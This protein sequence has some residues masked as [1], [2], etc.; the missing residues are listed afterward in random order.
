M[1]S[2]V[3]HSFERPKMIHAGRT[4]EHYGQTNVASVP[5]DVKRNEHIGREESKKRLFGASARANVRFC[6]IPFCF[7]VF[8][9]LP[10][11]KTPTT[12]L[13]VNSSTTVNNSG[14]F[15][16]AELCHLSEC[17]KMDVWAAILYLV[18]FIV[19]GPPSRRR[20]TRNPANALTCDVCKW[21]F[22]FS[23]DPFSIGATVVCGRPVDG[24][25]PP[26]CLIKWSTSK[27]V[28][29]LSET[30]SY[31]HTAGQLTCGLLTATA[32]LE[33]AISIKMDEKY[34]L[35]VQSMIDC[36]YKKGEQ[37]LGRQLT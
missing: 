30:I 2:F 34:V 12:Y 20:T 1:H 27:N 22:N 3:G 25:S 24:T 17:C 32:A 6:S 16:H 5:L 37:R 9:S 14:F 23:I 10:N 21:G 7:V 35:S 8:L 33:L 15:V 18:V 26:S 28:S 11:R 31:S 4:A 19:P 36:F 29:Q 13:N